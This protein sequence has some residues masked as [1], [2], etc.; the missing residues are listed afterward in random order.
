M[1]SVFESLCDSSGYDRG[2][3]APAADFCFDRQ[4]MLESFSRMHRR[5]RVCV[6]ARDLA[7]GDPQGAQ[8][9]ART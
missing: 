7:E 9:G 8:A 5:K 6:F 4:T 2:Q 3:L 1:L